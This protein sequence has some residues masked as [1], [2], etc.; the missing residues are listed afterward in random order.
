M[1]PRPRRLI[2]ILIVSILALLGYL[3]KDGYNSPLQREAVGFTGLK[4]DF[5][6]LQQEFNKVDTGWVY[7]EGCTG[8]GGVFDRDKATD[9][10]MAITNRQIK[11]P[12][13]LQQYLSTTTNSHL[14]TFKLKSDGKK[15]DQHYALATKYNMD[16][17]VCAI[18]IT[19][20][21]YG[22]VNDPRYIHQA[23]LQRLTTS[24]SLGLIDKT[25][26]L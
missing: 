12:E 13:K 17:S 19:A 25:N 4:Q 23:V 14:D 11:S 5:L 24:I 9:C 6:A 3:F 16:G 10:S 1:A 20:D 2:I 22:D 26:L 15:D 18:E 7:G 21:Y 8:S